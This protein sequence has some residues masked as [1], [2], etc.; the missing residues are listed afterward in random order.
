MYPVIYVARMGNWA[1]TL[2]HYVWACH[3]MRARLAPGRRVARQRLARRAD[4]EEARARHDPPFEDA[5]VSSVCSNLGGS[6]AG[7]R[8][9]GPESAPGRCDPVVATSQSSMSCRLLARSGSVARSGSAAGGGAAS[10]VVVGA[11]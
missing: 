8:M 1:F 4:E 9:G 6:R 5:A 7:L 3:A 11:V 10:G 2:L